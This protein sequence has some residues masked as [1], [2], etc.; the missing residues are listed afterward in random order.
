MNKH[1]NISNELKQLAPDANWPADVP[2]TVPAGYFDRFPETV[3]QQVHLLKPDFSGIV[4]PNHPYTTPAGYFDSLP[5]AIMQRIKGAEENPVEAEL[6]ALSPLIAAIPRQTPFTV[7][8]GYF[9]SLTVH[10]PAHVAP[11]LRIVHRNPVRKWIRYAVA[12]CLITFTSTTALLFLQKESHLNVEKQL[13][14][15]DN[16]DIEFYLQNHTDVFDN[17]AIFASFADVTAP[18]TLQQQLN[19]EIPPAAIEQY[20]QQSDLSKEVVPNH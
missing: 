8:A 4:I 15:L 2:F 17:D 16:Q 20:L 6:E 5:Q 19:E 18:E 9:D 10:P 14:G 1:Q 3:L 7:P 11:S 12:A 13:E